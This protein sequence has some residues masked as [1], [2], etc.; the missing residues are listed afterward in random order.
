[1]TRSP[2]IRELAQLLRLRGLRSATAMRDCV[3]C[4]RAVEDAETALARR[5]ARIAQWQAQRAELGRFIV[6]D[7]A[8]DLARFAASTAAGRAHLAEQHERDAYARLDDVRALEQARARLAAAQ[9]RRVREQA[10]EDE[11]RQMLR[12]AAST[13]ILHRDSVEAAELPVPT[14]RVAWS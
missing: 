2:E 9:A 10:R 4:A 13:A 3:R 6:G 12:Q 5:D 14:R 7:G 1:M 11:T 8:R